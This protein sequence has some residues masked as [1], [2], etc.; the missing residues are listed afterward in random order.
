MKSL[1]A[2]I[3]FVALPAAAQV[4]VPQ[5]PVPGEVVPIPAPPPGPTTAPP[6][7][8][9]NYQPTPPPIP[10]G[11]MVIPST[12]GRPTFTEQQIR[13][14]LMA[15]GYSSIAGLSVDGTGTWRGTAVRNGQN[16]GVTIDSNGMI[17]PR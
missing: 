16:L 13:S 11:L 15:N 9:P 12:P 17:S 10:P 14:K 5:T 4:V 8:P 6:P 7:S 3:V 1:F 2:A